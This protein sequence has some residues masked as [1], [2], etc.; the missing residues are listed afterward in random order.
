MAT[1]IFHDS[2]TR[3]RSVARATLKPGKGKVRVNRVLLTNHQPKM[4]RM[5]IEE[6]LVIAGETV[7]NI[8]ISVNVHGGG[9]NSQAEAVRLAIARVLTAFD[10]K[11]EK[12]FADYDRHLV[13]ADV[14]LKEPSKP[15]RQGKARS[16]R[17]KSYR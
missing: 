17:Q 1:K 4:A 16:K 13:V 15:N 2:G 3:K 9:V 14:R 6:P 11:L 5:K 8:D 12:P 10:K 7:K